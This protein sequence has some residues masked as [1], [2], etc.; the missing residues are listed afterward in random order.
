MDVL[1]D[2]LGNILV[3]ENGMELTTDTTVTVNRT[4]VPIV[5]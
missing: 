2:E 4:Y 1:T 5:L 3:D